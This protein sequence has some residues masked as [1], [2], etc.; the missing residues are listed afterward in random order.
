MGAGL[1]GPETALRT[2]VGRDMRHFVA[3]G[4]ASLFSLTAPVQAQDQAAQE[5]DPPAYRCPSAD[6]QV[7]AVDPDLA[8]HICDVE[9]Q[10]APALAACGMPDRSP[11]DI[12]VVQR[13]EAVGPHCQG[14]YVC[15]TDEIAVVAPDQL[16]TLEVLS[17]IYRSMQVADLFDSLVVHE[18]THARLTKALQGE[19]LS[20]ASHEYIAY[21][22]QFASLPDSVRQSLAAGRSTEP[23]DRSRINELTLFF[24]GPDAFAPLVW[25]HFQAEGNGCGFVKSLI[26]GSTILGLPPDS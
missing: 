2:G 12:Y 6:L 7:F 13:I 17:D 16:A 15:A 26:D 11:L 23:V 1:R 25:R 21:A 4:F 14:T 19:E 8:R 20:V 18:I 22:M 3:L 9:E 10:A 24:G 5:G